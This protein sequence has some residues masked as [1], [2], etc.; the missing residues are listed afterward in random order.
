MSPPRRIGWSVL[1]LLAL[2]GAAAGQEPAGEAVPPRWAYDVSLS[3][4]FLHDGSN[5][6]QPLATADQGPVHLETRYNYEARRTASFFVGWN[7]AFGDT[8]TFTLTPIAG[9]M[10][11]DAGGPILG[12]ELSLE[13][14]PLAWSSQGEWVTDLVGGTGG[15]LYAWS[16]LAVS[17]WEWLRLGVAAQ[18]TRVF[19]TPR[20]VI[21]GPL[22]GVSVWK[23]E[24]SAYWFQPGGMAQTFVTT[25]AVSF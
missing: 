7:L 5:Y 12:L 9:C 19:H 8:V 21:F 13:W 23:L 17:P 20:E 15:Y 22:V 3:W 25:V 4:Y 24:L 2:P 14:G 18:R 1:L 11:G 6:G 10:V 16:E